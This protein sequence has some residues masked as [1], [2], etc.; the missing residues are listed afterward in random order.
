MLGLANE[1][2]VSIWIQSV[3]KSSFHLAA[4]VRDVAERHHHLVAVT[5][6]L[7]TK[8]MSKKI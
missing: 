6:L 5:A 3:V 4:V 1:N 7:L 8:N 2:A